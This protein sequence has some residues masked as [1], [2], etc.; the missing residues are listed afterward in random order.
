M[1]AI[2][3]ANMVLQRLDTLVAAFP[4]ICLYI[5]SELFSRVHFKNYICISILLQSSNTIHISKY[6]PL[7]SLLL[8]E[9]RSTQQNKRNCLS[10]AEAS[11]S[12]SIWLILEHLAWHSGMLYLLRVQGAV[13]LSQTCQLPLG[14]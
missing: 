11:F 3:K 9:A 1:L 10:H 6:W 13:N 4:A 7:F 5:S 8:L 2:L 12:V 14:T